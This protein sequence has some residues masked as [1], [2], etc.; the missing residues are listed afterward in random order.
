MAENWVRDT[1]KDGLKE[2]RFWNPVDGEVYDDE[3]I[4][5]ARANLAT[6]LGHEHRLFEL[7]NHI[8]KKDY[9]QDQI[10][11]WKKLSR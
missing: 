1:E 5:W 4:A 2:E 8:L 11:I 3:V 9:R 6:Y 10:C 7:T